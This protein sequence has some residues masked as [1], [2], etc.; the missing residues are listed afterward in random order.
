MRKQR[1]DY[2]YSL[3]LEQQALE[4][5][6]IDVSHVLAVVANGYREPHTIMNHVYTTARG[7]ASI[8]VRF[9]PS[10]RPVMDSSST[11]AGSETWWIYPKDQNENVFGRAFI[12]GIIQCGKEA[13]N[14]IILCRKDPN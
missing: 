14:M 7:S 2:M 12:Y 6:V 3:I 10:R 4:I 5:G 9:L 13:G 1:N 11:N 8:L